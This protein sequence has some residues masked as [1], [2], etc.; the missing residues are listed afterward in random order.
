MAGNFTNRLPIRYDGSSRACETRR[1]GTGRLQGTPPVK[2]GCGFSGGILDI[3][4]KAGWPQGIATDLSTGPRRQM[5]KRQGKCGGRRLPLINLVVAPCARQAR[6]VRGRAAAKEPQTEQRNQ[7]DQG[8]E[9]FD[10]MKI[11]RQ[12]LVGFRL[13]LALCRD[14]NVK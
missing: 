13:C 11:V 4:I 5:S 10:P 8:R 3:F 12:L 2:R 7:S 9:R 14:A 6:E 1:A